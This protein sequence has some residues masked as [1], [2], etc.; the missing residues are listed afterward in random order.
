MDVEKVTLAF[1]D[2]FKGTM[3]ASGGSVPIGDAEG[4]L[5]PYNLLFGAL[6]SCFY[7]TFLSIATKKR[8]TFESASLTITGHKR[9]EVPPTLDQVEIQMTIVGASNEAGIRRS[10]ELGAQYCSIHAT[11]SKVAVVTVVLTFA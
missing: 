6:G 4:G 7:S 11:I 9:D 5:A 2:G 1:A 3:T 8:L 10:A